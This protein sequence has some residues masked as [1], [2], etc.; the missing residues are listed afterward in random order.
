MNK[1]IITSAVLS[2]CLAAAGSAFAQDRGH[3][4]RD[5]N[6][7]GQHAQRDNDRGQER[8]NDRNDYRPQNDRHDA[9]R[10]AGPRHDMRKGGRLPS[11]YRNK[12]YVVNDW[13]GHHL[14]R[15]P[16]GQHWV[17]TGGDYVLVGIATGVIASILLNN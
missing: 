7:G 2:L 5:D 1:N 4:G 14:S 8:R 3:D 6:R 17:Q 12:Q 13:Q 9:N 15:P 16:R 11:E 10:G